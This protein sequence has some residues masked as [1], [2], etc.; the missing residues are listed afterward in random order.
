MLGIDQFL[1]D[2]D[3]LGLG[4]GLGT[5]M[6]TQFVAFLMQD[7]TVTEIRVD[8]RPDNLRAIRCS[9]DNVERRWFMF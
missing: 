4:L 1:A 8:P 3:Q 9:A 5:K 6:V 2:G 7:P